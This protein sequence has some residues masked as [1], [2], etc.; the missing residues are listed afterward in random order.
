M[1]GLT[2][3]ARRAGRER[4]FTAFEL[5][6]VVTLVATMSGVS[7]PP[8]L[9][10]LD[11]YRAAA[12]TRYVA[13]RL[14]RMRMEAVLRSADVGAKFVLVGNQYT[15]RNYIDG[16]RNGISTADVQNGIDRPL[17][18]MERLTDYFAD[19]DF[20]A[21][22]GLPAVD[23]SGPPP[24]DDPI[25][26][27]TNDIVTFSANGSSSTGSLYIRSRTKQYVVRIYGDTGKTRLLVFDP[28]SRQWRPL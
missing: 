10:A 24:G 3:I 17:G 23:G 9:R 15:F 28:G 4:G 25:H 7:V 6:F 1:L 11:D 27:G 12:A 14:Q 16:N 2:Q 18:G 13:T 21:M 26:L 19:V 20:G 8:V 22:P 5:L